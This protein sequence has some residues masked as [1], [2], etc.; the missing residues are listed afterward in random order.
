M[1]LLVQDTESERI[2]N[3]PMVQ[4]TESERI[5]ERL[6]WYRTLKVRG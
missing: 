2:E 4:D 1:T 6:Y 5:E 3:D